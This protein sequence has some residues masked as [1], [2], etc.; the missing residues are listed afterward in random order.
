M[1]KKNGFTL[2]ELL[3][4]IALMISILVIAI[5]NFTSVSEG[6]RNES[7]SYV[8]SQI[9][10]A[11]EEYLTANE[12]LFEGLDADTGGNITVGKL[13]DEG[14]LNRVT[15]PRT[16]EA[17]NR[18][19]YVKVTKENNI[20]RT[21]Y[22]EEALDEKMCD[23]NDSTIV[24]SELGG[25]PNAN[26]SFYK[27]SNC[28]EVAEIGN[29]DSEENSWFNIESLG[30]ENKPLYIK[31]EPTEDSVDFKEISVKDNDNADINN[32]QPITN[33][34]GKKAYCVGLE[35]D[36][37][38]VNYNVVVTGDNG[39]TT[40]LTNSYN[41]DTVRPTFTY[42]LGYKL[43]N[44]WGPV[45]SNF[46]VCDSDV[47]Y[48]FTSGVYCTENSRS[49]SI[50][51]DSSVMNWDGYKLNNGEFSIYQVDIQ[52]PTGAGQFEMNN[53]NTDILI[54][55]NEVSCDYDNSKSNRFI[56]GS[57]N[58]PLQ[59]VSKVEVRLNGA[60]LDDINGNENEGIKPLDGGGVNL[61]IKNNYSNN[62]LE[63]GDT[64]NIQKNYYNVTRLTPS[65]VDATSGY[66]NNQE[67]VKVCIGSKDNNCHKYKIGQFT[68]HY[69]DHNLPDDKTDII[70]SFGEGILYFY[71]TD[72]A[73]NQSY[74]IIN[75]NG[76]LGE[77]LTINN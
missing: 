32:I 48:R 21:S 19:S 33:E 34:N 61:Y 41:K 43:F 12:Y 10:T 30:G 9:E 63:N 72:N 75:T 51:W 22:E 45:R 64:L 65:C 42:T 24:I 74:F 35:D 46:G 4:V 57:L 58:E 60:T 47:G 11:A 31:I 49:A 14:Y 2:I 44:I 62:A 71:R 76:K 37:K 25:A 16:G 38:G 28:S 55:G 67:S 39:K 17:V 15:D 54:N 50:V 36:G 7:W 6:K 26:I 68:F 5:V 52:F 69:N 13:V 59:N 73:G 53:N 56:C 20:Y 70:S 18:C 23:V 1:R 8:K 29:V 66:N 40:S 27:D 77:G 3:V